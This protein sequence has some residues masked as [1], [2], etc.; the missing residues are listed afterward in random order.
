VRGTDIAA[1][2]DETIL[3]Q[4]RET[5]QRVAAAA[6]QAAPASDV[7]LSAEDIAQDAMATLHQRGQP[8]PTASLLA[9]TIGI[10]KFKLKEA[11]RRSR[12]QVPQVPL[13]E[14]DRIAVPE[15]DDQVLGLMHYVWLLDH[16]APLDRMIVEWRQAGYSSREIAQALRRSGYPQM[17]ANN[18]DQRFFRALKTLRACLFAQDGT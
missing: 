14:T 12:T 7:L 1:P 5:V 11:T 4:I 9:W 3:R 6:L 18:V 17:T 15:A 16:I 8:A 2:A 13:P 10:A